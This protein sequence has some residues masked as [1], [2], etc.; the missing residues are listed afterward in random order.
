MTLTAP[1]ELLDPSGLRTLG[2]LLAGVLVR[3]GPIFGLA[4]A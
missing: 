1:I 4:S 2:E 3:Y